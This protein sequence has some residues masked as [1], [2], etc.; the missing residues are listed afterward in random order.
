MNDKVGDIVSVKL[1]CDTD[2]VMITTDKGQSIRMG[3]NGISILGR[4]TQGVKLIDL[5]AGEYV[6]GVAV[7]ADDKV[8][9]TDFGLNTN[10]SDHNA[11]MIKIRHFVY[12]LAVLLLLGCSVS[13]TNVEYK[14]GEKAL[15][16]HKYEEAIEH[17]KKVI[18]REPES[19]LAL[20]SAESKPRT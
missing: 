17:F 16:E 4:N 9:E 5:N 14:R 20:D 6:T 18:R 1:V 7:I 11:T 8:E 13:F 2:Q 3:V 15:D 12:P 10:N 19:K